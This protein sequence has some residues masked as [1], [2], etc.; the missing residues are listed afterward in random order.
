MQPIDIVEQVKST[1]KNYIKTAFPIV[2]PSLRTQVSEKV[3][4][5]SLLWRGPYLS[6]QR[7]YFRTN[8]TISDLASGLA[9]QGRLLSAGEYVDDKGE[10][11]PP[12][13]DWQLFAHQ[14]VAIERVLSGSNTIISSGT[15]SGKTEAFFLPILNYCLQN[16]GPGIR[17]LIL[18]PMNA[19][20]NDQYDRFA[21]YLAGTGV[22]FA[23]YTGDTP[24][25]EQDAERNGK[26]LRPETLC[27]EAIWYRKEIRKREQLPNILMTNY[28]MLEYLL[29]RRLDR[30][31]FDDR[32]HFLVL[33]EIHTY[34]G[35][36]GIEVA[37]LI[38][39]LKEHVG[40][41]DG[42]L[43]C[44]GTS[45]TV[46]G[47]S[48]DAVASFATELFGEKF[49]A[50][51]V[52][53]ERYQN[54]PA[55][56]GPYLPPCPT[57]AED[58]LQRLRDLSNLD[59][60][61]D[62]CL[63]HIAPADLVLECMDAVVKGDR[64]APAEFL[65]RVLSENV[66]FRTIED[67]LI[68]PRSLEEVTEHLLKSV[69]EGADETLL[70][71]EVEAYLLLGAKAKIAG[72]PLIRPKVHIFWRGLQGFYRCT[73]PKCG[74]LYTEFMDGCEV[75]RARCLPVEVCR[76]CGQDF[77]RGYPEDPQLP[78]DSFVQKKKTKRKKLQQLPSAFRLVDEDQG[79]QEPVHFTFEVHDNS[80]TAEDD[81][82]PD[83]M[84][85][86]EV[87]ARYCAACAEI[88]LDG[89]HKCGGE[90]DGVRADA[91]EL[92]TP[93]VY[94]GSI[95][96]CPACEAIYGGGLEVVTPLRSSTMVSINILV[97]GIFQHLDKE[98][99]RLLIFSDNR[100]DTAFQAAYLNLKHAQFVG[101]QLIYQVLQ[102]E[103][104]K[105][106]GPVSLE[107]L[108]TLIYERRDHY[109]VYCPKPTRQADGRLFYQIRRP[110]NP[111]DVAYEYAD[112]Q[113]SLLAEIAKPGS[114]RISLE[115]LG[116]LAGEY[117]RGE[118]T[119][120]EI[121]SR[122]RNLQAKHRIPAEEL[123]HLLAAILDEMRWKRA[124]SHPMMLKPLDES[125]KVFG[126][127]MLPCGFTLQKLNREGL[128][129]RTYGFFSAS[130]GETS[131]L[132]FVG[133][134]AGKG[135]SVPVL[136]DLIEFLAAE[137][138]LVARDIG[139]EK[140][141]HQ[142]QMVNHGRVMLRV[143]ETIFRCGRCRSVTT[144]NVRGVCSRWRCEGR[145]EPYNPAPDQNYYIET[146]MKRAPFRMLA[147]EHSAQ[148][149]GT[150]RIEIER[151]FKSGKS[152]VLV[153]TPTM[154]MGVDIGD[155]PSV[156][157]RNVPPG[158]ANYAQRSGRAGRKERI[159]LI[160]VFALNRAHDTYFFD[161]PSQMISGEIEP[162]DFTID[163]E[164]I[165]RRQI[166]SLILEKLDFQFRDSL[167]KL[168]PEGQ[169]ELTLPELESEIRTRR[170]LIVTSV[171]KAFQKDREEESK[172]Q[173][174]AW[175]T[176]Q[177]VGAIVD[178]FHK[179]L[180]Q[181]FQ[182][183]IVERDALFQEILNIALEKAK[184]GRSQ[185]KLAAQMTERETYLYKLLDQIDGAYPLSYLSDQG[186]LPSY[187]FP[188][189]TARLIAK[190]EVK[191]PILRGMGVALREYAP[192]NTVYMDGKKYQVIGLD[193][194]RSSVPDLNEAYKACGNCTYV[195]FDAGATHCPHCREELLPQKSQVLFAKSFVAEQAEAIGPDEEYRQR[196]FYGGITYLLPNGGGSDTSAMGGVQL[197]YQRRGEVFVSNTGLREENGKG[198]SICRSCGYWHAPTN[199]N[200]FEDHKLLHDRR[201]SCGGNSDRFHLGYRFATD[202]L[203]LSFQ[204]V[205]AQ[206]EEFFASIKAALIEAA[207]SIVGAEAGEISGFN[208]TM[209]IEGETRRDLILY[210]NVAGGAGYVRKASANME[211]VLQAARQMLDGCQC[212][213]SCYKCLRSYEN[214]FEHKLLDKTLIQS[215]LD[216][217]IVLNSAEEKERLAA[218][219]AGA[220]RYCGT[221]GSAWLQRRWR[222]V[223][224]SLC[225]V[226]TSV[227]N[228][229]PAQAAAWGELLATYKKENPECDVELG[230]V[231]IPKL[232]EL[233][234]QSFL[235]VKA[236]MDLMEA[237][238]RLVK[239][240]ALP[241]GSWRLVFGAGSKEM[242]AVGAIED[243]I[244]L[245]AGL[246]GNAIVYQTDGA[247]CQQ[248]LD[249][250]RS[251]LA[252]GKPISVTDL[253]APKQ[254]EYTV[255]DIVEGDYGK[256]YQSLFGSYIGQARSIRIVD[257]YVRL[258]FQV[259]NIE[260][261]LGVVREP[262]GCRVELVTMFERNEKFGLSEESRSRERLDALKSRLER[263]GFQF[264]YRF[265]P[266]M[267]DRM[268]ETENWQIVLG[269]G[270][271]FYY[272]PEPGQR[273]R[274]A[275]G[276]KIIYIPRGAAA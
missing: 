89:D 110:E 108:Q 194:H 41:L 138:F 74:Q 12:F 159:A 113:L 221:N 39:R 46:K 130:G 20:A 43:V 182:P 229:R 102:E 219:G 233:T 81:T 125:V 177:S 163:N 201:K 50:A 223:G 155:L 55:Q 171:L 90:G 179:N 115:G 268:I 156:F 269:R 228:E 174:L 76:S 4:E 9:L 232:S 204:D 57:I 48:A 45:A 82:D 140:A 32:L 1:Y 136:T 14:Q 245:T 70:R 262:K 42:K 54:L 241:G 65:G 260:D 168:F 127:A 152:D 97:E 27:D 196:A 118:E 148:L 2:D 73:N 252:K 220:Q 244:A 157:M 202:V 112:I 86:Q 158:P 11:H 47:D 230:L 52:C 58:G 107:R 231:Q 62:F 8:E 143:P 44:V 33:D 71:R 25:D 60:V 6:L 188:S 167:G 210:D 206:S 275:R 250:L 147:H 199:K 149:A 7:P 59:I 37:C 79:N 68:A 151:S 172:R 34:Q 198:F 173:G 13:G 91:R 123:Y 225:A 134:V 265:D 270:L 38:R 111:D 23:R 119:L 109:S 24:E 212:E 266:E 66:L 190:D 207:T 176:A 53:T 137:G 72:Q 145:L 224:G 255:T 103:R 40:K 15:G 180:L 247:A 216:H 161:R 126:R 49:D 104:A 264:A 257:P 101:R 200:A 129:Y 5:A 208:R 19:L 141:S 222:S 51:T 139:N 114:R 246:D 193:F 242:L 186:L 142:V 150:R 209:T 205:P 120:R 56:R 164:R 226:V 78:L 132:N 135:S 93:R 240:S 96:K 122:A 267:H 243:E 272:P 258:E 249:T 218:F 61:Y 165:L 227:D 144:H 238:V 273:T 197:E 99:R 217:L 271:D 239:V 124:L 256:T 100:Q 87:S 183:W 128:P 3:E 235:S 31:L 153:C 64:E 203:I 178:Q 105:G 10:R 88:V 77:Y 80:D 213:K 181:A 92:R 21:K 117:F 169:S 36:R 121:A 259:R 154:E 22:T 185:P 162:P 195:T 116:L 189:D 215:Y 237:G 67:F 16:P 28:S 29:L 106:A 166:N 170:E 85:A 17:A 251:I 211:A 30:V 263:K 214:Q 234:E 18:Y 254:E 75:C 187:A 84:H 253:K 63:D 95:H 248:A 35:A 184:I 69:R 146:Y 98:Q 191:R 276:C 274:R 160:N 261:L 26:E 236:L 131:L 175:L 94:I 192:G 133:K 83:E